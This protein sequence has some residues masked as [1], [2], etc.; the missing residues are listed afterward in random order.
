MANITHIAAFRALQAFAPE[1]KINVIGNPWRDG[2]PGYRFYEH[3]LAQNPATV[4]AVIELAGKQKSPFPRR[5]AKAICAGST[6]VPVDCSR[7]TARSS[8]PRRS[9]RR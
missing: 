8:W 6:R 1:S 9:R 4:G 2:T 3:V 7:L 5:L